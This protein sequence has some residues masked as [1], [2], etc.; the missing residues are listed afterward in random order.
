LQTK[1]KNKNM[2]IKSITIDGF[3][4]IENSIIELNK[5][6]SIIALNNY[7][8]SNLIKA[9][10]FAQTFLN[11]VPKKRN[12]M[13]RY[14]PLIPINK[15]IASRNFIFGIE[16]ETN[17][18]SLK[19]L[20]YYSF[21][22]E[23]VKD[24]GKK[25]ARIVGES[26]KYMPLK[27]DARYKTI[28][29]RTITKSLYQS[30][31]TGRCDNEIKIGK[32]ELL[33]N[34]LLNFDNLFYFNLLDEINNINFAVV[35]SLSNPDRLFRTIS[36][37]IPANNLEMPI[38]SNTSFFVY[39]LKKKKPKQFELLKESIK[40]LLPNIEDFE[41]I[42]ID[43]KDEFEFE[44]DSEKIP[45]ELPEKL[46]DIRVKEYSNNQQ[47]TIANISSGSK[48][49]FYVLAMAMAG[50]LNKIPLITFEEVEN[51]IHP[52]LLQRLLIII[53]ALCDT[54]KIL[55]TSHSP[56]LIKYLEI[57]DILIGIPSTDGVARFRKIKKSKQSKLMNF[58]IEEENSIG[59]FIFDKLLDNSDD[60]FQE[61]IIEI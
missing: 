55:I 49:I 17:F 43:L 38:S 7:G 4:N 33:V 37:Y 15:K 3:C 44:S 20:V 31:K 53:D 58:A 14:K 41:P 42:E 23:W 28:I 30:S 16:F 5:I 29:K 1:A 18:N 56:Y 57:D 9:I 45:Y 60:F 2:N 47:T 32:N 59:D 54:T 13:M 12:S 26:L 6:S 8:K 22:F 25:G 51:S 11:Q 39:N 19:T 10:D 50:E 48:K 36:D 46:Y 24:D 34:K 40:S 21:S 52:A 61:F 27:K 35:D